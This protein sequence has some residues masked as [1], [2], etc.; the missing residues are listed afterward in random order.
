MY[1][2]YLFILPQS[3]KATE[4]PSNWVRRICFRSEILC[5]ACYITTAL[6]YRQQLPL[7]QIFKE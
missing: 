2:L 7:Q 3:L 4:I 6:C 1:P 5:I